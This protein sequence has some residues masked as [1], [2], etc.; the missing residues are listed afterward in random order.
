MARFLA[1]WLPHWEAECSLTVRLFVHQDTAERTFLLSASTVDCLHTSHADISKVLGDAAWI[2]PRGSGAC[3]S[4]PMY[5]AWKAGCDFILTMDDDCYPDGGTGATFLSHHLAAFTQDRWFRTIGGDEP[6][7]IPYTRLGTLPVMINHGLWTHVPDLDGPTALLR[8]R[9]SRSACLPRGHN[10]IPPGMA[11]PLCAMNVCYRREVIPAAY[12]LLM[13]VGAF[14]FDRFDDIWSGLMLK[15]IRDHVGWY[16]TSGD[17]VV[18]HNKASNPF[19]NLRKEA[20]A[21]EL[22][23]Y[24]WDFVLDAPLPAGGDV[25]HAYVALADQLRTFPDRVE[26]AA[27]HRGYFN[28]LADAMILWTGLFAPVGD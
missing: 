19:A 18:R 28:R 12:N 8:H 4:F 23:E 26:V 2:V 5:L 7:G 24:L 11:F 10:V 22:H 16:V 14:G 27:G 6:R 21:M 17:P 9:D 25:R 20:G 3:R 13:G 1:E 15:R